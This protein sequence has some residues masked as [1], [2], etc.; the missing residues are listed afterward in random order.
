MKTTWRALGSKEL[1]LVACSKNSVNGFLRV[2]RDP[3]QPGQL[4]LSTTR[5]GADN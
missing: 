4:D 1:A 5:L 2:G 3:A